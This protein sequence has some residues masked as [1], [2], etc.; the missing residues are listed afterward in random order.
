MWV[1]GTELCLWVSGIG[2]VKSVVSVVFGHDW[3]HQLD[4]GEREGEE[5]WVWSCPWGHCPEPCADVQGTGRQWDGHSLPAQCLQSIGT[6][7]CKG[8]MP[9]GRTRTSLD[10]AQSGESRY[11][12]LLLWIC[13]F[14]SGLM[15]LRQIGLDWTHHMSWSALFDI[16][17]VGSW[18]HFCQTF[19]ICVL[20]AVIHLP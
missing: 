15:V 4:A 14:T 5:T 9:H 11:H 19:I 3:S 7:V 6:P 2:T 13:S 20:I 17:T 1:K 12:C 8:W 10:P 16:N 18:N